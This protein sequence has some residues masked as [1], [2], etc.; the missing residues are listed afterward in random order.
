MLLINISQI[1]PEGLELREVLALDVDLRRGEETFSLSPGGRLDCHVDK[2]DGVSIHVRGRLKAALE[3]TCS[4]CL[5]SGM[6]SRT[7]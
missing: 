6:A 4:R 5:E 7:R 1:P 3:M 2:V